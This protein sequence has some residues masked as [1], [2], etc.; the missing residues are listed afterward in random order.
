MANDIL[1]KPGR[2]KKLK[3]HSRSFTVSVRLTQEELRIVNE[4]VIRCKLRGKSDFAR[5][6]LLYCAQHDI[7]LT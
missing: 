7:R 6:S 1:K 3:E 2:P 4:A 5:K